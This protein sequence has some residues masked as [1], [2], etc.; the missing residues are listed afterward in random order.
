MSDADIAAEVIKVA[1]HDWLLETY[2]PFTQYS[3]RS[4]ALVAEDGL[5]PVQRRILWQM[6]RE[7][8][9]PDSKH[10][11]AARVAGN[12]MA[13]H[14][15]ASTS[16]EDALARMGQKFSLRV[17]LIDPAGSVGIV[18]GDTPAAARYWEARLTIEAMELLKE[19]KDGGVEMG[20]NFDGELDE[21]AKLPVRWPV[22][23]ING[24][25]GIAVGYA[26][27]M[28]AHNP[29]EVMDACRAI[30][31]DP[32]LTLEKLLKIMPGPDLPTGGE[33]I[34]VDGIKEYYETGSGAFIV[35]GRYNIENLA[36]GKVRIIFY[37]LPYQISAEDVMVKIHDSQAVGKFKEILSVKDLTDK[38]NGLRL[39]I[40]TKAGANHLT[41]IQQLF[42]DTPL[43]NR[44]SVNATVLIEGHPLKTPMLN[45]LKSFI[46]LRREVT[47]RKAIGRIAKIEHRMHQLAG[48][49]AI[50]I[51]IDKAIKI[52]RGSDTTEIARKELCRVFKI[53]EEQASYILD[54]KLRSLTKQDSLAVQKEQA[55]LTSEKQGLE[56]ILNDPLLLNAAID[57]DLVATKKVIA[58]PR[59]T[60]ILGVTIDQDKEEQK[61]QAQEARDVNKNSIAFISRFADGRVLRTEFPFNYGSVKRLDYS[62]LVDQI[63]IKSQEKI[64]LIGSD[65]IARVIPVSYVTKDMISTPDKAGVK[66]P[67]GVKLVGIAKISALKT[68]TG[69]A[70]GTKKGV[71]KV[72]KP[73]FPNKEEFP[74]ILLDE[75]DSV[76]EARWMG[77]TIVG[78]YF[79]FVSKASNVLLFDASS[80]RASGAVAGGVKGFSLKDKDD[81]AIAFGWAKSPKNSIVI[82]S[83][84]KSIKVTDLSEIMPKGR[85]GQGVTLQ[86]LDKNET[87]LVNAYI[88]PTD[89][90]VAS[91]TEI[92][93]VINPPAVT[94]RAKRGIPLPGEVNFGVLTYGKG[95]AGDDE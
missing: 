44:F 91:I 46:D 67:K 15:H 33:L 4:R 57:A 49:L 47:T 22:S 30:L 51:D 27:K 50:L 3:I 32:E 28:S 69:I 20:R 13:F 79:Y 65:G 2:M 59:R 36:R 58:S 37:E 29:S 75:G 40:E 60:T 45:M 82:S 8:I 38:N 74:V 1:A 34:G 42:K 11:K 12:T 43:Q 83:T 53:D 55:E 5:K 81:E 48:I 90:I 72:V 6:F 56:L 7:G 86:T 18:T 19:I 88:A 63:K 89:S 85:G 41:V 17:P 78:S 52:I 95:P 16:I 10:M 77:S 26:S 23:I 93:A 64:A 9:G 31:K 21:P 76:I 24:T 25:E 92:G 94:T 62:P 61:V 84:A 87:G 39:V 14:P 80:I 73:I 66:F 68:D 54:M 70:I 71:V 35:R